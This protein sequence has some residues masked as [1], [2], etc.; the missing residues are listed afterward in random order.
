M[1]TVRPQMMRVV[2]NAGKNNC[3]K[4][5]LLYQKLHLRASKGLEIILPIQMKDF[6]ATRVVSLMILI[7]IL[8]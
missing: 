3:K 1:K 7:Q 5:T 8:S 2:G 6:P 4:E